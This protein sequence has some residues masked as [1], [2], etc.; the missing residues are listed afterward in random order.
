MKFDYIVIGGGLC[1]LMAG[2]TLARNGKKTAVI[3]SGQSALHFCAGSFGLLGKQNGKY[4]D[5]PLSAIADLK[6]SHPYRKIGADKVAEI[7]DSVPAI[8]KEAGISVSGNTKKNHFTFTPFGLPRPSWLTFDGYTSFSDVSEFSKKDVMIVSIQGF[9]ESY[10]AFMAENLAKQGFNP[11]IV[12]INLQRLTKL[13][14]SNF[15]MRAVSVAKQMDND[16]IEEFAN[17]IN[18]SA[19][20]NELVLI[21]AVLGINS[22]KPLNRLRELVSN[23]LFVVPTIPVSVSGV[24]IQNSLQRYF[25]SLGGTYL[26]GDHVDRGF[27]NGDNVES[28]QTSNLGDDLLTAD[29]Y[30]LASG[31]LLSE[32]IVATP[33]GFNE[34]V[35]GL[36]INSPANRD[37][38]YNQEFFGTQPYRSFGVKTDS[39][40]H[41][42]ING[43][44]IKNL[45]VAGA[46][47][48]ECD[49]L[50]EDSGAGSA[51]VTGIYT[52]DL[53]MCEYNKN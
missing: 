12:T 3:S 26:L 51:I 32:G 29:A 41:P 33:T 42:S 36:D 1:G 50:S 35:F 46:V 20:E 16:T 52:A 44:V 34:Q 39:N 6:D 19:K 25:E 31:S 30:I 4:V 24:R 14:K 21:P 47:L 23:D 5:S 53:A 37:E 15:D 2:I 8:L 45:Y 9:L 10:P 22:E 38:W 11:R 28:V 27:V 18:S 49:S 40:F 7:A 17:K 13:S 43:R 48:A